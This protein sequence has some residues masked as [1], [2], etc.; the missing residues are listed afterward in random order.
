MKNKSALQ[1]CIECI[2]N[3]YPYRSRFK[4]CNLTMEVCI[5]DIKL[6][7]IKKENTNG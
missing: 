3:G 6:E 7:Q 4:M 1:T 2:K 5:Q